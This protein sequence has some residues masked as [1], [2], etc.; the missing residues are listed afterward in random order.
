[1]SKL[2]NKG[3]FRKFRHLKCSIDKTLGDNF[4][5]HEDARFLYLFIFT[6]FFTF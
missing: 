4:L 6:C 2:R 1:M 5:V 3:G